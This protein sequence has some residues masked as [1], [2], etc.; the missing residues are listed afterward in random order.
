MWRLFASLYLIEILH[1]TTTRLLALFLILWLYLIEILHQTTTPCPTLLHCHPLYLIE[2]LHQT[3]TPEAR[4]PVSP[5]LY[6]IEILHQTTT[7]QTLICRIVRCILSKFYIKP[8]PG[9]P[10]RVIM[11]V[12]S[13]R[14][15]TS[16]HN[17]AFV[18][19]SDTRVV[20]YRNSTSNHNSSALFPILLTLYL[21]EIL[22]QTTTESLW[23]ECFRCCILSKF[24]IKPQRRESSTT[25]GKVVSY[26][27]STS[28]HNSAPA[29]YEEMRVV[30]YRNSTS[31]HNLWAECLNG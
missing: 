31:N 9:Q 14:N 25:D 26:R 1:Q 19:R 17:S 10:S 30:S 21:I 6:L 7:P 3:T 27:N 18:I 16:N 23:E 15:S 29:G 11:L 12:V 13:Y 5:S 24:Y 8:Q 4:P 22:H 28:N 2:I 20:S